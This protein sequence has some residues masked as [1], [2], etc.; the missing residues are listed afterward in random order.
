MNQEEGTVVKVASRN[1]IFKI[2]LCLCIYIYACLHVCIN[3]LFYDVVVLLSELPQTVSSSGRKNEADL[4][5]FEIM[6]HAR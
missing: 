2:N 1:L 5:S 3:C 6:K 4:I